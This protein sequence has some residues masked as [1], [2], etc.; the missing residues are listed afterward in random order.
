[1]AWT[2]SSCGGKEFVS[3]TDLVGG[4][5]RQTRAGR[6]TP[7]LR[8][9]RGGGSRPRRAGPRTVTGVTARP[10]AMA[11]GEAPLNG[12]VAQ[13]GHDLRTPLNAIIGFSDIMQHELLG[14][15]DADRYQGYASHIRESGEALVKAVEDTLVLT[16]LIARS[17]AG[18]LGPVDVG[19]ALTGAV[20]MI[21]TEVE[22]RD[23]AVVI[24]QGQNLRARGDGQALEQALLDVLVTMVA[25]TPCKG[26][27]TISARRAKGRLDVSIQA[28]RCDHPAGTARDVPGRSLSIARTLLELQGGALRLGSEAGCPAHARISLPT[29]RR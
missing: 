29:G 17:G 12:V 16:Q 25:A 21:R 24:P 1:M 13:M 9:L 18:R 19:A 2:S 22:R 20:A 6:G 7:A 28:A 5:G 27:I 15:L 3:P 10:E 14:P 4:R 26:T 11:R 8:V 23:I